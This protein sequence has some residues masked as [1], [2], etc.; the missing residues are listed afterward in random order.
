[1][2]KF[3]FLFFFTIHLNTFAHAQLPI[4]NVRGRIS[5]EHNVHCT[6]QTGCT[7]IQYKQCVT[8]QVSLSTR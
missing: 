7:N 6:V 2:K 8:K 1:M 5:A 3:K 4:V